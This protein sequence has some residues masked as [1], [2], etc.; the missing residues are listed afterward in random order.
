MAT[1][2]LKYPGAAIDAILD[3]AYDL[4]NAGYIFRGL[5]SEYSNTPTERSWVLAGEGE[6][7]HGFTSPVPKGYIGVCVFNGTSWTGKLLKCVSIDSTPTSGS[8]NAVSSGGAYASISQLADTVNEA[9]DNLTFTDTTPSAFLGEYITEKVSTTDGGLERILTY[10]TI[11][12]ATTSKA[13]LLS[14]ADKAK[15]D[16]ILGN[17]RSLE[18]DDTTS[19]ADLGDKIVESIKATIGGTEETI[20]TFQLLAATASKAGL[21][22]AADK[23]KLD[24]L[25]SSGYQFAGISTP[26]TTPISTTSK[27]FYIATEAGTYFNAVTVTQGINILSW[28]GTSWSAVQ[29]VGIDDEPTAGS[30]NLVTSGSVATIRDLLIGNA[31]TEVTLTSN[32]GYVTPTGKISDNNVGY[33]TDPISLSKDDA[34]IVYT[35][36]SV[37]ISVISEYN[38]GT[39]TPLLLGNKDIDIFSTYTFVA[40]KDMQVVISGYNRNFGLTTCKKLV[41]ADYTFIDNILKMLSQMPQPSGIVKEA[42]G[43]FADIH[44]FPI[45]TFYQ[46]TNSEVYSQI[47]NRPEG[48]TGGFGVYTFAP[49]TLGNVKMQILQSGG[50]KLYI[51]A[52]WGNVGWSDWITLSDVLNQVPKVSGYVPDATGD[53]ADIHTFPVNTFYQCTNSSVY[54]Q[55]ANRPEGIQGGFGVYTF[56]PSSTDKNVVLQILQSGGNKLYLSVKWAIRGWSDWINIADATDAV[57]TIGT[58]NNSIV[59]AFDNIVSVGDSLTRSTVYI[60]DTSPKTR[61]AYNPWPKVVKKVC[62]LD[63]YRIFATSGATSKT[64]WNEYKDEFSVPQNGKTLCTIYLGTNNWFEDTIETSAPESEVE[65]YRTAWADD[66]TGCMCKIIQTFINFG[67]KIILIRPHAGGVYPASE[68]PVGWTLADTNEVIRKMALR[69]NIPYIDSADFNPT[70][71]KYHYWP[72]LTGSN[73]L[74]LNDL[75]YACF[76]GKFIEEVNKLDTDMMKLLIPN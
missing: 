24:A 63:E 33:Y 71:I 54:S 3:T 70:D 37:R 40:D 61:Q 68:V 48:I 28:N 23:A 5:A 12:A 20:S 51:S 36:S 52:K 35:A 31:S 34:I 22:S 38:D 17:L 4:Q 60:S 29:V 8:T 66:Y 45:N 62:G 9:L 76:A 15:L 67:A 32:D 55:I 72:D 18:I 59:A 13:G 19:Y 47:A 58:I 41:C 75:G 26:S 42:T 65:N 73:G 56:A 11:L 49:S 21:L 30:S 57:K 43:D 14:A 1:Y 74:H 16:A 2:D 46:C 44:T 53:F 6:T 69:F 27:I 39:Y 7:G 25:W 50:N 10:F 64:I